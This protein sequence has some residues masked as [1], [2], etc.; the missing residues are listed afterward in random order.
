MTILYFV[1]PCARSVYGEQ[2]HPSPLPNF[3]PKDEVQKEKKA[4]RPA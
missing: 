3:V 1:K 2:C 4:T